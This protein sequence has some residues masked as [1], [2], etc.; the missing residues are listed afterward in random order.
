QRCMSL[1]P[2]IVCSAE[3]CQQDLSITSDQ[4]I[5]RFDILMYETMLMNE[6]ER[7]S[8]LL[9]IWHKLFRVCKAPTTIFFTE[10]VMDSFRRIFHY[11][12]GS[13]ILNLTKVIDRQNVGMLQ[14]SNALRLVKETVLPFFVEL[15]GA[16]HFECQ[17][18]TEWRRFTHLVNVAIG[19]CANKSDYF[20]DANV[21]SLNEKVTS[22]TG[23]S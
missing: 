19:A 17:Y 1:H 18:A 12:V 5:A 16:Q 8:C 9:D 13:S 3:I 4:Q 14:M 6:V 15:L 11:Q 21:S 7:R 22:F 10:E 23:F 2:K 20:V